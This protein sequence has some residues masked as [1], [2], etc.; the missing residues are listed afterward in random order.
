MEGNS[1]S[2]E[3]SVRLGMGDGPGSPGHVAVMCREYV[4]EEESDTLSVACL[5]SPGSRRWFMGQC[6]LLL[7]SAQSTEVRAQV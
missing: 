4:S 1:C 6:V 3:Q 7:H 5:K 2:A